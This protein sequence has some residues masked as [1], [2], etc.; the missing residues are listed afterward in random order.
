MLDKVSELYAVQNELK[1]NTESLSRD[2]TKREFELQKIVL[3][4]TEVILQTDENERRK[5]K[6]VF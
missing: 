5:L 4:Q 2:N 3:E 6:E 1:L